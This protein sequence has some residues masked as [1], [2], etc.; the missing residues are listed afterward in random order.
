MNKTE[1][2]ELVTEIIADL[3]LVT[4]SRYRVTAKTTRRIVQWL[5]QGY[6]LEEFK[7]VHRHKY[8]E[9]RD[10]ESERFLQ[11]ATLHAMSHF[12]DYLEASENV[13]LRKKVGVYIEDGN[14]EHDF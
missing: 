13:N 3:N 2:D 9:W 14:D 10:T 4:K 8:M 12:E 11:P 7:K 5:S 6:G 1:Y